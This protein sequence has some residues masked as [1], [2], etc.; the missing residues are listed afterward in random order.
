MFWGISPLR[1]PLWPCVALSPISLLLRSLLSRNA[2]VQSPGTA[3]TLTLP[4][5]TLTTL[6]LKTSSSFLPQQKFIQFS[7]SSVASVLGIK[8]SHPK[9]EPVLLC[10]LP[11]PCS[12][13]GFM[14][15]Q[16]S[17]SLGSFLWQ[18]V[19]LVAVSELHTL[20][21]PEQS[22]QLESPKHFGNSFNYSQ[23]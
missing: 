12:Q 18:N 5:I 19:S 1:L 22:V 20:L 4:Y 3:S 14:I 23:F 15:P 9:S 16:S 8:C 7:R 10:V 11:V 21:F 6:L 13:W 2:A 17:S